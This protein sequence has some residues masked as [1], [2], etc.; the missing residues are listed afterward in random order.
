MKI[1]V[2]GAGKV[3]SALGTKL[4]STGHQVRYGSREPSDAA[5]TV[6]HRDLGG[7]ETALAT[8]HAA[9]LFFATVMALHTPSFNLTISR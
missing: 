6:P 8:E 4:A 1:A 3:G 2:L 9:P 5:E 7:I